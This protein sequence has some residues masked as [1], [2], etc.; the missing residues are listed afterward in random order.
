MAQEWARAFDKGATG[1]TAVAP[2]GWASGTA[3]LGKEPVLEF[4][5]GELVQLKSDYVKM[6][7]VVVR[8]DQVECTWRLANGDMK[9]ATFQTSYLEHTTKQ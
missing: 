3:A 6:I 8:G 5:A 9:I 1:R 2:E 7:V 4:C